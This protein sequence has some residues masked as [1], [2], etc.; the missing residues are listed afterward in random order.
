MYI[1]PRMFLHGTARFCRILG[2][3]LCL[4]GAVHIL[5]GWPGH[6]LV[7]AAMPADVECADGLGLTGD[8]LCGVENEL[9]PECF[10]AFLFLPTG[11]SGHVPASEELIPDGPVQAIDHP[12]QLS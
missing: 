4:L 5:A 3:A 10:G 6:G 7:S 12:P 2:F 8:D 9:A 1:H 11:L